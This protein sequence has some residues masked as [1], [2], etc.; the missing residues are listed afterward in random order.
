[1]SSSAAISTR[2]SAPRIMRPAFSQ[3]VATHISRSRSMWRCARNGQG[4]KTD[5]IS[6]RIDQYH[7]HPLFRQPKEE[8]RHGG[9]PTPNPKHSTWGWEVW[10][11]FPGFSGLS[12]GRKKSVRDSEQEQLYNHMELLRKQIEEDPYSALFGRRLEPFYKLDKSDTS[13]NGYLQ[14]F[15]KT[16][17]PT[18]ARSAELTQKQK[19]SNSNH[20]GLQYDPISGRMA[21]MPPIA[22]ESKNEETKAGSHQIVDCSPGSE[23]DAKFVSNPNLL[24]DGQFQP[25]ISKLHTE[26]PLGSHAIVECP[27]GSELDAFFQSNTVASRDANIRTQVLRETT[28]KPDVSIDRSPNNELESLFVSGSIESEHAPLETFKDIE[29]KKRLNSD[30]GLASG[31]NVECSPGSGLEAKFISEPASQSVD[32]I[33]SELENQRPCGPV[34]VPIDCPP[35]NELDAKFSSELAS[36]NPHTGNT[37]HQEA[38]SSGQSGSHSSVECS[39]SSEVETPVLSE[40]ASQDSSESRA[41]TTVDCPP[42]SESKAKFMS[43]PTSNSDGQLKPAT[44]VELDNSNKADI[45]IECAPGNEL[46]AR[47]VSDVAS[48]KSSFKAE[49]LGTLQASDIR[50]QHA[51]EE[52]KTQQTRS[53]DFDASEDH[54]GDFYLQQQKLATENEKQTPSRH[55]SPEF[56]IL[57]YDAS[58]SQV[59]TAQASSFFGINESV[60]SSEILFRLHNAA[61]FLPYFDKMQQ[62]GYEIATGGGDIL[63]FRKIHNASRPDALNHT[64]QTGHEDPHCL[65]NSPAEPKALHHESSNSFK[66]SSASGHED[67][68]PTKPNSFFRK[69]GRRMLFGATITVATCYAIGVVTEFFRTGGKDGRGIDGFTVFESDRRRWD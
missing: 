37:S 12:S 19:G 41:Q 17:K 59:T 48:A 11:S 44:T 13:F 26:A 62:N 67:E 31:T 34:S 63:V 25:G 1:M 7:R 39:P 29:P 50:A 20:V 35:G 9:S 54:I 5:R 6:R 69:A 15:M 2:A 4:E 8:V 18:R 33:S 58:T 38:I 27:P 30:S 53:L 24:E 32:T 45:S 61:K 49:N 57:A 23:V 66:P 46:E 16:K 64:H 47:L 52:T 43:N 10:R 55:L 3:L 56:H 68:K 36:P 51:S 42:E 14:S 40:L 21:P 28:K 60:K 65:S 22:S